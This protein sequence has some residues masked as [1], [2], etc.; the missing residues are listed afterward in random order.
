MQDS[1]YLEMDMSKDFPIYFVTEVMNYFGFYNG[2]FQSV[3]YFS[4]NVL[5]L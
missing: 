4:Y 3:V 1:R 5:Q 2:F